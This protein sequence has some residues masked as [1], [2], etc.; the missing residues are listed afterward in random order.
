MFVDCASADFGDGLCFEMQG[1]FEPCK[2]LGHR[3]DIFINSKKSFLSYSMDRIGFCKHLFSCFSSCS[4]HSSGGAY[5]LAQPL[6]QIHLAAEK[7]F[8]ILNNSYYSKFCIYV[9]MNI[10]YEN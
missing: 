8:A 4:T 2:C 6:P 1:I 5:R 10:M 3:K 9:N 7:Y